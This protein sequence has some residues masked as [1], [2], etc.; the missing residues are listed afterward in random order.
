MSLSAYACSVSAA[1]SSPPKQ[2]EPSKRAG[3]SFLRHDGTVLTKTARSWICSRPRSRRG[4]E[5]I[6]ASTMRGSRASSVHPATPA[7]MHPR[8][9]L[10]LLEDAHWIDPTSLDVFSRLVE[11]LP[12][13]RALLVVT[14]RPEFAPPW[15]GRAH[16][17]S[18]QLSRCAFPFGADTE[19][20]RQ[21]PTTSSTEARVAVR[22]GLLAFPILRPAAGSLSVGAQ[23]HATSRA[24][25]AVDFDPPIYNVQKQQGKTAGS[26]HFGNRNALKH[27]E[28]S[29]ETLALKREIQA[30]ARTA[31]ET[32]AAIE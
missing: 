10:A 17:A 3:V 30:L 26:N 32:I 25:H 7:L 12:S 2:H 24:S 13:L 18:L 16:L 27:G 19:G 31:R 14:F 21:A 6:L 9:V 20:M 4:P 1:L 23:D 15:A 8:P 11:R 28:F 29:A 5:K 22:R